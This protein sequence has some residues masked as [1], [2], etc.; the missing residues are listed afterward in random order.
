MVNQVTGK[1]SVVVTQHR[2]AGVAGMGVLRKGGN[3]IDAAVAAAMTLCVV[4]PTNVGFGGYGGTMIV[5][6]ASTGRVRALDFDS[7]APLAYRAADYANPKVAHHGYL[8]VGVP[9]VVAGLSAA[10][11]RY[12]TMDWGTVSAHAVEMAE[13]GIEVTPA[14]AS[15]LK[16]WQTS[17]DPASLHA[18]FPD[19]KVPRLHE[20]WRQPDVAKLV[21]ELAGDPRAFYTGE[22]ARRIVKQVR[23][24]GGL[25]AMEDFEHFDAT[26]TDPLTVNYRGFDL[27]TPPPPAGGIT[28][29]SILKTLEQ[30]DLPHFERWGA[31]Y[32]DLFLE[33][34]KLC[35]QDR[36]R[37]LGDP[38]VVKVPMREMLSAEAAVERVRRIR[39]GDTA[40]PAGLPGPPAGEHTV[41]VVSA[42]AAGNVVSVTLTHGE[43][44]GSH[45]A[46]EGLGLL[47]GHGMSRFD[48]VAGHPNAP[49]PGKRMHHNM[50]PLLIFKE[51]KPRAGVGMP[52]G[53][54]IVT[55]TA[56]L[57]VSLLDFGATPAETVSAPRIHVESAEPVQTGGTVP[58]TVAGELELM[59]HSVKRVPALG[60]PAGVAWI[61]EGGTITAACSAGTEGVGGI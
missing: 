22:P 18:I 52:G 43:S 4:S 34:A 32:D 8:S 44:F 50:S 29:L 30:F 56:Q 20:T 12:G 16:A 46:I 35:W 17:A 25:L 41:N 54:K 9:G 39:A 15:A 31:R 40:P 2:E 60:G 19:G 28:T 14:L 36:V 23:E 55:V 10:L 7:R 27:Y 48:Y 24:H 5:Y 53:T 45:V 49:A 6:L 21:R 57:V 33:A 26:E 51:G 3:A 47:L 61:G 38:E 59:G 11:K 1:R 13:K 42:D 58:E 37:W